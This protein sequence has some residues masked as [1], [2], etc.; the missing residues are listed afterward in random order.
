MWQHHGHNV[1]AL[2]SEKELHLLTIAK[3]NKPNTVDKVIITKVLFIFAYLLFSH[4]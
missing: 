2:I 4:V 1:Y 3:I